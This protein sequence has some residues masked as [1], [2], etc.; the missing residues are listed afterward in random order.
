MGLNAA[1]DRA[2]ELHDSAVECLERFGDNGDDLRRLAGE[3][4]GRNG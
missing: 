1:R 4:I 2:R 3:I